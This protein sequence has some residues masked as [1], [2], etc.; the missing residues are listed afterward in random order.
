[1]NI[2]GSQL[3]SS[4][5]IS[6][7]MEYFDRQDLTNH[8]QPPMVVGLLQQNDALSLAEPPVSG[9]ESSNTVRNIPTNINPV[10]LFDS[11]FLSKNKELFSGVVNPFASTNYRSGGWPA[12][13][14]S[15]FF[16][17]RT[18]YMLQFNPYDLISQEPKPELATL[19]EKIESAW[20]D[21]NQS[22]L[23]YSFDERQTFK[24]NNT[25]CLTFVNMIRWLTTIDTESLRHCLKLD[26]FQSKGELDKYAV[27]EHDFVYSEVE[28]NF[29][30]TR[31]E[32]ESGSAGFDTLREL[33][34]KLGLHSEEILGAAPPSLLTSY[35]PLL[36][37]EK[38]QD[39]LIDAL[40]TNL[41]SWPVSA[42]NC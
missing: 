12:Y 16:G 36:I 11:L 14:F 38:N 6:G 30:L 29:Q 41:G 19:I 5:Y 10:K 35:L 32:H 2:I 23:G 33:F 37:L 15:S 26:G 13:F 20:D 9:N 18:H 7:K 31:Y 17:I 28:K 22:I 42:P 24:K 3:P 40:K 4:D 25:T 34:P 1:M 39:R 8:T 27:D 21:E